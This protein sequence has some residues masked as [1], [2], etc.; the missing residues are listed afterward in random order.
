MRLEAGLIMRKGKTG[1][2]LHHEQELVSRMK[3]T[4]KRNLRYYVTA[5]G[6]MEGKEGT[7]QKA[8]STSPKPAH[9]GLPQAPTTTKKR[10]A[11]LT[12]NKSIEIQTSQ[13]H[14]CSSHPAFLLSACGG[15]VPLPSQQLHLGTISYMMLRTGPS[16]LCQSI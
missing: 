1:V 7:N 4:A 9:P 12:G 3:R 6:V 11:A 14:I 2:N 15:R 5:K 13:P 16:A 8:C 10:G